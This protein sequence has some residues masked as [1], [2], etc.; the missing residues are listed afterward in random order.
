M[1]M[2]R[3]IDDEENMDDMEYMRQLQAKFGDD[4]DSY[5]TLVK[6]YSTEKEAQGYNLKED[7]WVC[8]KCTKINQM[9]NYHCRKWYS[10]NEIVKEMVYQKR[11]MSDKTRSV[12]ANRPYQYDQ[13][14]ANDKD[15][16]NSFKRKEH[17]DYLKEKWIWRH[18]R[19]RVSTLA[20]YCENWHKLKQDSDEKLPHC[21]TCFKSLSIK[22][23]PECKDCK[24]KKSTIGRE[25]IPEKRGSLYNTP[26]VTS[27][28]MD[29]TAK[30]NVSYRCGRWAKHNRY[31]NEWIPYENTRCRA[32]HVRDIYFI[33]WNDWGETS[34][35]LSRLQTHEWRRLK[36]VYN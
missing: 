23:K 8:E 4:D 24:A 16:T 10:P 22:T 5:N 9:P 30:L 3:S 34:S 19:T 28:K 12:R 31:Q 33:K 6:Q 18:C 1:L 32:G 35:R 14:T 26:Q 21:Q 15:L 25:R 11:I 29:N 13:S 2:I 17:T 7:D 36:Y 20:T 27:T